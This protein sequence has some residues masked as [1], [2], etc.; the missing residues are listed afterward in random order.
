[1]NVLYYAD[2]NEIE[3]ESDVNEYGGHATAILWNTTEHLGC[4]SS[5]CSGDE[6]GDEWAYFV[7]QFDPP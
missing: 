3:G 1:M 6:N 7:C 4:A 2:N 5:L